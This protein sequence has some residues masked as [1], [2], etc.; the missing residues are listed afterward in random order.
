MALASQTVQETF[1]QTCVAWQAIPH[2]DTGDPG[3]TVVR[4]DDIDNPTAAALV[5]DPVNVAFTVTLAQ[6]ISPTPD[7]LLA[8]LMD[9]TV[10]LAKQVDDKVLPYVRSKAK[11]PELSV[12]AAPQAPQ[13]I[14]DQLIPARAAVED[15]GYRAPSCIIT[16]TAG[17]VALTQLSGGYS[18]LEPLA[19]AANVNSVQRGAILD[20]TSA[21]AN[22]KIKMI[23]L[24][25]RQRIA[26]GRAADA[27][28]GEEPVDLAVSVLPSLQVTG[29]NS[30]NGIDLTLRIRFATRIKDASGIVAIKGT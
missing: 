4:A 6:V 25:R 5:L 14:L 18:V 29:E 27:S 26:H 23:L 9:K 8:V 24:G 19:N 7:A 2:W 28:A 16:N 12:G 22:T 11:A 10:D 17:L 1:E 20:N 3:Q 15:G 21:A 30:T 13:T